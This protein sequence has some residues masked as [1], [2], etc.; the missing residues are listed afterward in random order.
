[1]WLSTH[2]VP[3]HFFYLP[4]VCTAISLRLANSGFIEGDGGGGRQRELMMWQTRHVMMSCDDVAIAT[5]A[6]QVM[7]LVPTWRN[8]VISHCIFLDLGLI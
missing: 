6:E 3:I 8:L 2:P 5:E 7:A 4:T 1:M